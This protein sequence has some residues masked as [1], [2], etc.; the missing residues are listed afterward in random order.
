MNMFFQKIHTLLSGLCFQIR[1]RIKSSVYLLRIPIFKHK[2]CDVEI[3][4]SSVI[5]HPFF[6]I[7][8]KPYKALK[9]MFND[10]NYLKLLRRNITAYLQKPKDS[11][12]PLHLLDQWHIF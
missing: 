4:F 1:E 11:L 7:I 3:I 12:H 8:I 10:S 2:C 6:Y 9:N 5:Y